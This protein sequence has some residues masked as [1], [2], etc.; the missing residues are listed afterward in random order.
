M[1]RSVEMGKTVVKIMIRTLIIIAAVL[2]IAAAAFSLYMSRTLSFPRGRLTLDG[3]REWARSHGVWGELEK[4]ETTEYTVEG[5]DGYTLH[6]ELVY[7]DETKAGDK[8]VI[9]SHGYNSNRNGAAKYVPVYIDL[10][11]NCVIYDL[12]GHGENDMTV[13]TIG[14]YESQDLLKLIDDTYERYGDYIYL[15]LHGESMGSSTTLSALGSA[16]KVHFAVADCGFTNL[17]ELIGS[18]FESNHI[19]FMEPSV[20]MCNRLVYGWSMKDTHAVDNIKGCTVPICFIHGAED[21]FISPDHSERLK[22]AAGGYTELHIVDG[23]AHAQSREILGK[24]EYRKI[25]SSFLD[26]VEQQEKNAEE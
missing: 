14:N 11:Y 1:R 21:T 12:R 16:P 4:Y 15:G 19:K 8:Y 24:T 26:K 22:D 17:Y 5:M 10:G 7:T 25:V 2:F 18:G 20:D 23:A 9:I 3:E 13:C 6:C